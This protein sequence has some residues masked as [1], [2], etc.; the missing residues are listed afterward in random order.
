MKQRLEVEQS[1]GARGGRSVRRRSQ[2]GPPLPPAGAATRGRQELAGLPQRRT[3]SFGPGATLASTSGC[4]PGGRSP[5]GLAGGSWHRVRRGLARASTERSP[6][7]QRN[8]RR[9]PKELLPTQ[10]VSSSRRGRRPAG[11]SP[12]LMSAA[13]LA[14]CLADIAVRCPWS[15]PRCRREANTLPALP[16]S[17]L[18][19][20]GPGMQ[21]ELKAFH[22][23]P[24]I[25]L[26]A[27]AAVRQA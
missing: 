25:R 1:R 10:P 24:E 21:L 3:L 20:P 18:Q 15:L 7:S 5:R 27:G 4:L 23:H 26:A 6:R 16:I 14:C 11:H 17:Q 8:K 19:Q 22:H 13:G 9:A 12:C 2:P